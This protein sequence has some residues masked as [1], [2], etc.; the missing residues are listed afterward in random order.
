MAI[1]SPFGI[2]PSLIPPTGYGTTYGTSQLM[3]RSGAGF[4]QSSPGA[5][6]GSSFL[7]GIGGGGPTGAPAMPGWM[8]PEQAQV[9][10][11]FGIDQQFGIPPIG[12]SGG[13]GGG[14][15]PGKATKSPSSSSNLSLSPDQMTALQN[16][17]TG[18]TG[19]QSYQ[20]QQPG[21]TQVN[22][23]SSSTM[24]TTNPNIG[25]K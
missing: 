4:L 5:P 2:D 13:G 19:I 11:L 15:Q 21:V 22:S 14:M 7:Q 25:M 6:G 10:Q 1:I 16:W 23:T 3:G 18:I 12:P 24:S 20:Q 9:N 17:L 8:Q